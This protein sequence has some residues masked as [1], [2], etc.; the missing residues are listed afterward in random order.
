MIRI[1][2]MVVCARAEH[3]LH[4]YRSGLCVDQEQLEA[5]RACLEVLAAS[6]DEGEDDG[7]GKDSDGSGGTA[8]DS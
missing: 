4:L 5:A 3:A 2:R 6:H 7:A 1:R 8:G